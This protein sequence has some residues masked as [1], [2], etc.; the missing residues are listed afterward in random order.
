MH[1]SSSSIDIDRSL[2]VSSDDMVLVEVLRDAVDLDRQSHRNVS[3][4]VFR[5]P[6]QWSPK[7][8]GYGT[9]G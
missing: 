1:G 4:L 6:V 2:D 3:R 8:P 5:E 9:G 7:R